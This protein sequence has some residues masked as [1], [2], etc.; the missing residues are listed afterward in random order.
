MTS[1][2]RALLAPLVLS[3]GLLLGACGDDEGADPDQLAAFCDRVREFDAT[4]S[5]S[6][7]EDADR[8]RE[9]ADLAPDDIQ[10]DVET[11]ADAFADSGDPDAAD[12]LNEAGERVI[13]YI[14]ENCDIDLPG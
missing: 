9:L 12:R 6:E 13:P 3:G 11:I 10:D 2:R 4:D 1:Y 8:W 7:A 14:E 5:G